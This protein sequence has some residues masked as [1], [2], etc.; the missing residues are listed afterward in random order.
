MSPLVDIGANLGHDTFRTDLSAVLGRAREAGVGQI[1]VTGAAEEESRTAQA[2]AARYPDMLRSTAGVHPHFSRDWNDSTAD[3]LRELAGR[4]EVVAL[5]ETGLDFNRN[6]SSRQEQE[7]AFEA[8]LELAIELQMP[9]F[10]HERDAHERFAT[11]V[12]RHRHQ[13]T[14]ALIHCFTG[15]ARALDTYLDLDLHVGITGWICDER[16]GAHLHPLVRRIPTER[17]MIET[18]APY[19]LPR[20]LRPK[21]KRRRNE[22]MHLPHVLQTVARC[23]E[24]PAALLATTTTETARAFFGLPSCVRTHDG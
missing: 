15:D 22:P 7:R 5:G 9:V 18:D 17:L 16:R 19:L 6:L 4:T 20:D 21:P 12:A 14:G 24:E 13:L 3:T 1:I 11:I 10:M 2:I 8:Q 23:R